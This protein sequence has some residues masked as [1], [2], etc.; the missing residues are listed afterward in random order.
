MKKNL[1]FNIFKKSYINFKKLFLICFFSILFNF[2][3]AKSDIIIIENCYDGDT[4]TTTNKERIRLACIDTPEIKG[5]RANP[6]K[7]KYARDYLNSLVKGKEIIIKRI[8][9]DRYGRTVGEIFINK[10]NIQK[11]LVDIGL[12]RVYK[13]YAYQCDWSRKLIEKN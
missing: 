6:E 11:H 13:K 8:T 12:A 4:C 9:Y 10:K 3:Y 5:K 7:A 2:S 1:E